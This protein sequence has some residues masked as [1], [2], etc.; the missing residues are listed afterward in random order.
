MRVLLEKEYPDVHLLVVSSENQTIIP[1]LCAVS[2]ALLGPAPLLAEVDCI[3]GQR[4]EIDEQWSR[5]LMGSETGVSDLTPT[6]PS[7]SHAEEALEASCGRQ[8][9]PKVVLRDGCRLPKWG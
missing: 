4:N 8:E 9:R 5:T 1:L 6:L 7:P 3:R 2:F